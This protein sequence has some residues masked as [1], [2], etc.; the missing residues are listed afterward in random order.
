[1]A[2]R[3]G[4]MLHQ[5]DVK[6]AFLDGSLDEDIYTDQHAGYL[7]E[8]QPDYVRKLKRSLYGLKQSRR[9]WNQTIDGFMIK[10]VFKKCESDHCIYIKRDDQ[11]MTLVV[12]YVDDL[13]LANSNN[14]LLKVYQDGAEHTLQN[15]KSR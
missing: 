14:K 10:M 7:D 11:G 8:K 6:T 5:M 1:M 2:A 15:D 4:L 9:M 3:Y 13:I 12:L